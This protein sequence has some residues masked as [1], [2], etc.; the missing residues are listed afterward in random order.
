MGT[1][2][3]LKNKYRKLFHIC[4]LSAGY[5]PLFQKQ[6]YWEDYKDFIE[7]FVSDNES[8]IVDEYGFE[9]SLF[10]FMT[11]IEDRRSKAVCS[12][13]R[14]ISYSIYVDSYGIYFCTKEFS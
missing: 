11:L 14:S 4:K 3:Y 13:D 7:Y 5:P 8:R 1:N 2:I 9:Y 10:K 6:A 12:F